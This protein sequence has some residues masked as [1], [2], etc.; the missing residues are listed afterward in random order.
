MLLATLG[1]AAFAVSVIG[2]SSRTRELPARATASL[3][4]I[5]QSH[6]PF[7][8]R[9]AE[10][11][12]SFVSLDGASHVAKLSVHGAATDARTGWIEY[13]PARPERARFV[14]ERDDVPAGAGW[15]LLV[16]CAA[17]LPL[18]LRSALPNAPALLW[19]LG[20]QM[21]S[22]LVVAA[23]G[24][25]LAGA[26]LVNGQHFELA[27]PP[28]HASLGAPGSAIAT[29]EKYSGYPAISDMLRSIDDLQRDGAGQLADG[30]H[31]LIDAARRAEVEPPP[32][33]I[34][35]VRWTTGLRDL[36]AAAAAELRD[37]STLRDSGDD[38][39]V[40]AKAVVEVQRLADVV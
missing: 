1:V 38:A 12:A 2:A 18:R 21:R 36:T 25:A 30:L 3:D 8:R 9:E 34:L 16:A 5:E 19:R 15:C 32:S 6:T 26:T 37:I 13:D 10:Y 31:G 29:W 14:G 23:T 20:P 27:A 40:L 22:I 35:R 17:I 4:I 7:G 28:A 39:A 11:L 24:C 33:P